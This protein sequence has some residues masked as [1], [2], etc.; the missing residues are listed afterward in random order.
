MAERGLIQIKRPQRCREAK[1]RL[2]AMNEYINEISRRDALCAWKQMRAEASESAFSASDQKRFVEF[3]DYFHASFKSEL[4]FCERGLD[5][6]NLYERF[7]SQMKDVQVSRAVEMLV[8]RGYSEDV[9]L[10]AVGEMLW[11][12]VNA[13]NGVLKKLAQKCPNRRS[14]RR[15]TC[16]LNP[17]TLAETLDLPSVTQADLEDAFHLITTTWGSLKLQL[18]A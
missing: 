9:A 15:T 8:D 16:P 13:D 11:Y 1:L 17:G 6:V 3:V 10:I 7:A 14:R 4:T 5:C 12:I 18:A 2:S